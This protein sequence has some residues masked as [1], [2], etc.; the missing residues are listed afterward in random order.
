MNGLWG[1]EKEGNKMEGMERRK[2]R[3]KRKKKYL[4]LIQN[5]RQAHIDDPPLVLR[6]D[7]NR[8]VLGALSPVEQADGAIGRTCHDQVAAGFFVAG[9]GSDWDHRVF[10]RDVLGK[11]KEG[12][13]GR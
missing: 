3:G 2:G 10:G 11:G 8:D 12:R 5:L 6:E 4:L 1:K 13:G 9:E 7:P